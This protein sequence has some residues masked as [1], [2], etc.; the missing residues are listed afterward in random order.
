MKTEVRNEFILEA[1]KSACNEWKLKI[2][3]ECPKLF[4]SKLEVGKWYKDTYKGREKNIV[5]ITEIDK[6]KNTY[7]Y[8][9]IYEEF[10]NTEEKNK[11]GK[12]LYNNIA[13]D[14]LIPATEEE[15]KEALIKEVKKRGFKEGVKYTSVG[16]YSKG[17]EHQLKFKLTYYIEDDMLTDGAGGSIYYK[18]KWAE[19]ISNPIEE[20][21]NDL[22]KQINELKKQL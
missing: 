11:N 7:G 4:K 9:F 8:G 19:I 17:S 1:H 13:S 16:F 14:F 21:I 22:Q 20:K 10:T 6:E 2:E 12:C 18:G 5:F 15:V 3:K